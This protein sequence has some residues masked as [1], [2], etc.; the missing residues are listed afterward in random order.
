MTR[1]ALFVLLL[2]AFLDSLA[3]GLVYPLFSSMLFDL[4]WHF[5]APE[6]SNAIRGLWLGIFISAAPLMAMLIS[7]VVGNFSDRHGRRPVIISC[8]CFG[9]LAWLLGAWSVAHQSL[10]G[11]ALAR[12]IN[13][14]SVGSFAV[15]NACIADI[16]ESQE[17]KGRRYSWMG[18]AFGTGYAVGPLMGGV[19][20]GESVLWAENLVRPFWVASVLTGLNL[21]FVF[22]WLPET[23]GT[24]PENHTPR[25]LLS[26]IRELANVDVRLLILLGATFLFTFGWSFYID[27]IPV[28][29]VQ[30]FH[31]TASQVSL[32]FG[33]GALWYIVSCGLLV[34]PLLRRQSPLVLFSAAAVA[35]CLCI[36]ALFVVNT[37]TAY[38]CLLPLQN[39]AASF[40]FP[41]A[42]TAISG[43]APPNHQGK[44]MGY[45]ASAESLG[46]GVGPLTS[47]PFLGI[48]LLMPVALGGLAVLAAGLI[49]MRLKKFDPAKP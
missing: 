2:L 25:T 30:K 28:W 33:Y 22:L 35:L 4:K 48:H 3:F 8:L 34:G 21:L 18:M 39:V 19:L 43:M 10:Y 46:F 23:Y 17:K 14:I 36:W 47:G 16:S 12:T 13:G 37:P 31:F 9:S 5:V 38:W 40:L 11:M 29:W 6:T 15:A 24:R 32:F 41:V 26:S 7:P 1:R 44:I 27:F 45:H 20:A 49:V 42:A